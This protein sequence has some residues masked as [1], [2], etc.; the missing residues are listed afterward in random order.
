MRSP[1][2]I[3]SRSAPRGRRGAKVSLSSARTPSLRPPANRGKN[4]NADQSCDAAGNGPAA[5]LRQI[6]AAG[7]CRSRSGRPPTR[8][9]ARE[10]QGGGPL[11][12]R[13][14]RYQRQPPPPPA[15]G[16]ETT[17]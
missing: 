7:D 13:P 1:I 14:L 16:G 15:R 5:P 4:Q 3:V 8:R 17:R 12:F 6:E 11:P 10:N 9:I 2:E